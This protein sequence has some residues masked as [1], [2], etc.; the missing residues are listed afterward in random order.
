MPGL[1]AL[2]AVILAACTGSGSTDGSSPNAIAS[3]SGS[4]AAVVA[5]TVPQ[6]TTAPSAPVVASPSSAWPSGVPI[7]N[8]EHCPPTP[9][10]STGKTADGMQI[11]GDPAFVDHVGVALD[12]LKSGAPDQ[13]AEVL[14]NVVLIWQVE[15]FSGMCYD[16]GIYRV[17]QETAYA[18]GYGKDRQAIWL[19]GTIVHD[20]CHRAR[21]V[22]GLSPSGRDAEL[23]CLSVQEKALKK[24]DTPGSFAGYVQNLIETVDDPASQY[25]TNPNRHW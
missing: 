2:L 7:L 11:N 17:G 15:S 25:W 21:F 12:A 19:A 5:T 16:T 18:P 8:P 22:A 20:G 1:V 23:A 6:V 24:I 10:P 13:Y 3:A 4:T 9:P 14:A